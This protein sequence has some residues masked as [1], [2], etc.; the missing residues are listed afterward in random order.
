MENLNGHI[1]MKLIKLNFP[2]NNAPGS[3]TPLVHSIKDLRKN[4]S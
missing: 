3:M 2:T 1:S 4:M